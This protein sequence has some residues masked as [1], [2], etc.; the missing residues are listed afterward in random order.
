MTIKD[1]GIRHGDR[2]VALCYKKMSL[3][4]KVV[5]EGETVFL[6]GIDREDRRFCHNIMALKL[7]IQDYLGVPCAVQ[8]LHR[9]D[10]TPILYEDSALQYK[11]YRLTKKL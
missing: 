7:A 6:L 5:F 11:T 4:T 1:Y 9:E 10:W 3:W 2:I 8:E